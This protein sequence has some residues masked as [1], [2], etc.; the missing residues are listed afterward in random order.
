VK[1]LK[2]LLTNKRRIKLKRKAGRKKMDAKDKV[3]YENFNVSF[4][5]EELEKIN[6][7]IEAI[8]LAEN[9]KS[10][11]AILQFLI[12]SYDNKNN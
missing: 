11:R 2:K 7:K 9:L 3:K 6:E 5:P 1:F 12:E 4:R 10:K 8:G